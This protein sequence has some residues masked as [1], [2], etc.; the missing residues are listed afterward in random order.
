LPHT[1]GAQARDDLL[2]PARG[3]FFVQNIREHFK[4][5]LQRLA[6]LYMGNRD[7]FQ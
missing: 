7:D 6:A 3:K 4:V 1:P 2:L 5:A